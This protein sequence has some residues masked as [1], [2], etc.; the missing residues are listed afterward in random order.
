MNTQNL[1]ESTTPPEVHYEMNLRGMSEKQPEALT[2]DEIA[3][4]YADN[5][6]NPMRFA[7][8]IERAHG[9]TG[10]EE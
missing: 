2:D 8:S 1:N 7:R 4:I 9:I 6:I 5:Q 10:D 3:D